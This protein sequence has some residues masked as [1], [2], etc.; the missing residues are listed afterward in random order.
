M[1]RVNKSKEEI[2]ADMQKTSLLQ[3]KNDLK[4]L[5]EKHGYRL[6]PVMYYSKMGAFPQIEV[7]KTK[8]EPKE[9]S[10]V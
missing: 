9:E 8:D 10:V 1:K 7:V 6:E 5:E 3:F 2:V 4:A